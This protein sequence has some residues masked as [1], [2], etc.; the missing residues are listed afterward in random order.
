[1]YSKNFQV[2]EEAIQESY[3]KLSTFKGDK[4]EAKYLMR[5]A[6][7]LI[8]RTTKDNVFTIFNSGLKLLQFILN[9]FYK[10]HS[11]S[12]NEL[13]HIVERCLANILARTGDTNARLRQ[14]AYDFIVEMSM[15]D[16]VKPLHVI[17]VQCTVPL[18]PNC[19]PRLALSRVEI[20]SD[21]IKCLGSKENGFTIENISKFCSEALEHTS[22]DVRE[23]A[24]KIII[25][26]YQEYGNVIRK[27]LPQDNEMNRRNKKY[28]IIYEAF[29]K[30]NGK[31]TH[32]DDKVC[33]AY[34]PLCL[35]F[36]SNFFVRFDQN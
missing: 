17:P 4:D 23:A 24:T 11:I 1:L 33:S 31:L 35:F 12:K 9:S 25:Q 6:I 16:D 29:D 19:A 3:Q 13:I 21:L 18:K 22:G 20:V 7:L 27:Y 32:L 8:T 15:F 2:R 14:R 26:M 34:P 5:S 10:Q 28:R 36:T 30:V